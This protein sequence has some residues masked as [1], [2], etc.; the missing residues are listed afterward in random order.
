[1]RPPVS[2][3]MRTPSRDLR[4]GP[5]TLPA[6]TI[7]NI[8]LGVMGNSALNYA[9]PEL[10]LPVRL[11]HFSSPSMSLAELPCGLGFARSAK[12]FPGLLSSGLIVELGPHCCCHAGM[13][14]FRRAE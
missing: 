11:A 5:Y 1:M 3:T 10:Y 8:N 13:P 12:V 7:I 6:G 14:L 2:G 4:L 9:S